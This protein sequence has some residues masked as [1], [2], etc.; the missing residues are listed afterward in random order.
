MSDL[1]CIQ[2]VIPGVAVSGLICMHLITPD[3]AGG[4]CSF[5][6]VQPNLTQYTYAAR[7]PS[8]A[9]RACGAPAAAAGG[10]AVQPASC[11]SGGPHREKRISVSGAAPAAAA[12]HAHLAPPRPGI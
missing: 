8:S 7:R 5:H 2:S 1:G 9:G 4:Q 6:E 11:S 3:N 12:C 10:A